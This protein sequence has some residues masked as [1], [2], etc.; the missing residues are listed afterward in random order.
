[1]PQKLDVLEGDNRL[2]IGM[3]L[4]LIWMEKS[5]YFLYLCMLKKFTVSSN[6]FFKSDTSNMTVSHLACLAPESEP[7]MTF[8]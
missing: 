2:H 3:L 4:T 8:D 1:M 6:F 5:K 7:N